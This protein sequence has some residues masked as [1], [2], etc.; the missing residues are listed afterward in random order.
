[1]TLDKLIKAA[2]VAM[3]IAF[4]QDAEVSIG[5]ALIDSSIKRTPH[6][7]IAEGKAADVMNDVADNLG[8]K[9]WVADKQIQMVRKFAPLLDFAIA[10]SH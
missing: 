4:S 8:L 3:G 9:W 7:F 10:L 5:K 6:G 2:G 1:M